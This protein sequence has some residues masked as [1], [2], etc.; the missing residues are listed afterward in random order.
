MIQLVSDA[1]YWQSPMGHGDSLGPKRNIH[2]SSILFTCIEYVWLENCL[3]SKATKIMTN[4]LKRALPGDHTEK[5][6]LCASVPEC[7]HR[8]DNMSIG[9]ILWG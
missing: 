2:S 1:F 8:L 4:H 5:G 9:T 3:H 6:A 7:L